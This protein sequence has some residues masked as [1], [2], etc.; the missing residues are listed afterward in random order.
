LF[1]DWIRELNN[2][3]STNRSPVNFDWTRSSAVAKRW[4]DRSKRD[5][6]IPPQA[7]RQQTPPRGAFV[8]FGPNRPLRYRRIS[9][10]SI[11]GTSI[12]LLRGRISRCGARRTL[13]T[14]PVFA[15]PVG[16][17]FARSRRFRE[18]RLTRKSN[19]GAVYQAKCAENARL[20]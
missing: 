9:A 14:C 3:G 16:T 8:V 18:V 5:G 20:C 7:T 2:A 12:N 1:G 17:N 15:K 6:H 19:K 13:G 10:P 4:P 11:Q